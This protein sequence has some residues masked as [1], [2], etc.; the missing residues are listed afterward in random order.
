V[1][2]HH[3]DGR[4][5]RYM[6]TVGRHATINH[7]PSHHH[8]MFLSNFLTS[9]ETTNYWFSMPAFRRDHW[10]TNNNLRGLSHFYLPVLVLFSFLTGMTWILLSLKDGTFT[11]KGA[12][13]VFALLAV[14]IAAEIVVLV[15][16][17]IRERG[18]KEDKES[19]SETSPTT[20][21]G[22][23]GL[24]E[25]LRGVPQCLRKSAA[26]SGCD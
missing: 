5:S 18:L 2:Q 17:C 11:R 23:S 24:C 3:N 10:N 20:S 22:G 9:L 6:A 4:P 19:Q 12:I 26:L 7:L 25:G 21:G 1:Q 8:T 15:V 14:L 16:W 13:A